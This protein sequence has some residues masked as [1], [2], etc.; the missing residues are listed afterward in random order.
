MKRPWNLLVKI[1]RLRN[2]S[3]AIEIESR[4]TV[5]VR[6][7]SDGRSLLQAFQNLSAWM[8]VDI[9]RSHGND[10]EPRPHGSEQISVGAAGAAMMCDFQY[11]S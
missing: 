5:N 3:V 4:G 1:R 6:T 11:V 2:D 10:G 7:I 8:M 9:A